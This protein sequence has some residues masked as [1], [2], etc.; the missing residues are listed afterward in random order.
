MLVY[1][2]DG[3]F[4]GLLTCIFEAFY[5]RQSP[6]M[7]L[8]SIRLQQ[9]LFYNYCFIETD[10]EKAKRVYDSIK[11][12]I[13]SNA[14]RNTYHAYLSEYDDAGLHIY[15][16]LKLGWQVGCSIDNHLAVES[17]LYVVNTARRVFGE[18]HRMY[19]LLRFRLAASDVYYASIEP[20]HNILTLLAKHFSERMA[21]QKW[22]IHDVKRSIAAVYNTAE[23]FITD[24]DA[25]HHILKNSIEESYQ[26]LW[27]EFFRSISI[28]ERKNLRLQMQH[29]PK[30]YWK[31]LIE[32][33]I[34]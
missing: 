21:G 4:D 19:G 18:G 28:P 29:M 1:V 31:H 2:Y 11:K 27:K 17:V 13:S 8:S 34:F 30:M 15:K 22:V 24:F 9:N 10:Q 32:K 7:I 3:S 33:D 16:Y 12:K 5:R 14:L 6:D 25:N 26:E 23:W 20:V